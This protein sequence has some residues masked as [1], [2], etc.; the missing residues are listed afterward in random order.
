MIQRNQ[1]CDAETP[2]TPLDWRETQKFVVAITEMFSV[3]ERS[4]W[5]TAFAAA[6]AAG[7]IREERNDGQ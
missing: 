1:R 6:G 5:N 2:A 3:N 4:K 7:Y